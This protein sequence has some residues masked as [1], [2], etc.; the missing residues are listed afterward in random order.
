MYKKKLIYLMCEK[1]GF[2]LT[3]KK[4]SV[5]HENTSP[6]LLWYQMI[7]AKDSCNWSLNS[8][9]IM[10]KELFNN[11]PSNA[12]IYQWIE[13]LGSNNDLMQVLFICCTVLVN[14]SELSLSRKIRRV[15]S[16]M[17]LFRGVAT[18]MHFRHV[19]THNFF[20]KNVLLM[21]NDK[22]RITYYNYVCF[23]NKVLLLCLLYWWQTSTSWK[24]NICNVTLTNSLKLTVNFIFKGFVLT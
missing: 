13:E 7:R 24:I 23:W 2:L 20:P 4:N 12:L 19:P 22:Q 17:S 5:K 15:F 21:K 10:S 9:S 11:Y 18:V 14:K 3:W 6:L 8:H 1:K 16:S